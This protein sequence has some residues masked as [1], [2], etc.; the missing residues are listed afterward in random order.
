VRRRARTDLRGGRIVKA[1]PTATF[2]PTFACLGD[3]SDRRGR[4]DPF[5][6]IINLHNLART[7]LVHS[8]AMPNKGW[9][10]AAGVDP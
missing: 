6:S 2:W 7:D 1:V 4:V 5:T 8:K 10:G 3:P 9:K